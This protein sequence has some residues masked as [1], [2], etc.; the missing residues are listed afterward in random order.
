MTATRVANP[1]RYCAALVDRLRRGTF[2]L[3][4]GVSIAE[5]RAAERQYQARLQQAPGGDR[6]TTDL[7]MARLSD[8]LRASLERMRPRVAEGAIGPGHDSNTPNTPPAD[9]AND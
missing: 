1:I 5:R 6:T 8:E 9:D 3:E 4:L 7:H 2:T